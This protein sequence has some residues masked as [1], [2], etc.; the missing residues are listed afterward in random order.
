MT[1]FAAPSRAPRSDAS[2]VVVPTVRGHGAP[3]RIA[4]VSEP[5]SG[6]VGRYVVELA[7]A[8]KAR[9]HAVDLFHGTERIEQ[10]WLE[11]V[12]AAGIPTHALQVGRNPSPGDA[13]QILALIRGLAAEGPFDIVHAHSSKAGILARLAQPRNGRV[14]YTTHA[15]ATL[16]PFASAPLGLVT[17][18]AESM[19]GRLTSGRVVSVSVEEHDHLLSL[20]IPAH[21][22]VTV[23]NAVDVPDLFC[24]A[25]VRKRWGIAPGDRVVGF[26]GRFSRQKQPLLFV[27][28]IEALAE[29]GERVVG[30]MLGSGEEGEALLRRLAS[31][32]ARDKI[33]VEEPKGE[34]RQ[35]IGAFDCLCLPSAYEGFPLVLLE[36][37]ALGVPIVASSVGG[38]AATTDSGACGT[39]VDSDDPH[40]FAEAVREILL[41]EPTALSVACRMLYERRFTHRRLVDETEA[42]YRAVLRETRAP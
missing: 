2:T 8:L 25:S 41:R 16:N 22:L 24:D 28:I 9:G 18:V 12:R 6:G 36:A 15:V 4:F 35:S 19:L 17:R 3:L 42:L 7:C 34:V 30:V 33:I 38:A 31:S 20:G 40:A 13:G 39:V 1:S 26:V 37:L 21:S 14:V 11:R 10:G 32:P 5:L 29:A 23:E 27:D